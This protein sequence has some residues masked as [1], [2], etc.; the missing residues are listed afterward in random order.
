MNTRKKSNSQKTTR[1][2]PTPKITPCEV[3]GQPGYFRAVFADG[4]TQITQ[5]P[6]ARALAEIRKRV[7]YVNARED[8]FRHH[9][10]MM[11]I[12]LL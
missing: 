5:G 12:K 7:A 1:K 4:S 9:S 6:R 2:F 8:Y 11:K 3:D 10:A